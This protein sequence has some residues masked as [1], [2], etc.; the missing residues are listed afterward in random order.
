MHGC[1]DIY[2]CMMRCEDNIEKQKEIKMVSEINR[3]VKRMYEERQYIIHK[4]FG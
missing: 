1:K 3:G 2:K 4:G